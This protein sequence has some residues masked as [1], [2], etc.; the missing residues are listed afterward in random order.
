MY[1]LEVCQK[2]DVFFGIFFDELVFLFDEIFPWLKSY[3]HFSCIKPKF[4]W[5]KPKFP[6]LKPWATIK[7]CAYHIKKSVLLLSKTNRLTRFGFYLFTTRV[8]ALTGIYALGW[9]RNYTLGQKRNYSDYLYLPY[10]QTG[11]MHVK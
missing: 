1:F 8:E 7:P 10:G 9:V 4:P 3:F 6:W 2:R 11:Q 5:L